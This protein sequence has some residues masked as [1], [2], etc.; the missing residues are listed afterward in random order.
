MNIPNQFEEVRIFI[1]DEGLVP[2][3][4]KVTRA[5]VAPIERHCITGEKPAHE[6]G[7]RSAGRPKQEVEV[8]RHQRP[9]KAFH[10]HLF[11][12]RLKTL[13]EIV[14]IVIVEEDVP[15]FDTANDDVLKEIRNI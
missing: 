1:A 4:K 15:A 11:Q 8:I 14:A 6:P 5:V 9:R 2:V 12:K 10:V 13:K 3:L 7:E